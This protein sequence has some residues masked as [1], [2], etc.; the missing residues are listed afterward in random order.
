MFLC[1]IKKIWLWLNRKQNKT[2]TLLQ[3]CLTI[4]SADCGNPKISATSEINNPF[5]LRVA[6]F[7]LELAYF[8]VPKGTTKWTGCTADC[9]ESP[10]QPAAHLSV[11]MLL[12]M[13]Q[14]WLAVP[15]RFCI[16]SLST[17][18]LCSTGS[19]K[20]SSRT[21]ARAQ[22]LYGIDL[23]DRAPL[24]IPLP[25]LSHRASASS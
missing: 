7:H 12:F 15:L 21:P 11:H 17:T 10:K 18:V 8:N 9:L 3:A 13:H 16:K 25:L 6:Y 24:E 1:C 23:H 2:K 20:S 22:L 14:M 5:H 19:D 4:I